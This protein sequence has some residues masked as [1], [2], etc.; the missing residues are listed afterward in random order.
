MITALNQRWRERRDLYRPAGEVIRTIQYEVAPL[1]DDTTPRTFVERHHYSGTYVA[2]RFRF[3]LFRGAELVGVAV[4]SH[5]CNDKALTNVFPGDALESV[6]LGRFVL[7]DDV[8]GNGETWFLGRCF[9]QLRT[10]GLNGVLSFSDP[11]PR[12]ALDG[13][14]VFRGHV[15]TIY[16]AHNARFLGRATARTLRLLPDGRSF[17]PYARQKVR[18]GKRGQAYAAGQLVA[19]G[20]APLEGDPAAWLAREIPRVTRTLRH[21][22]NYRYAWG[23]TR[24]ATRALPDG[25]PYPKFSRA[26]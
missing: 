11:V 7:T 23:L 24:A 1:A 21:P 10:E 15:G 17:H 14:V 3:G 13:R 12:T 8:P 18:S 22:G 26:A 19:A 4:F 9:E 5:P 6:E 2:A 16:Q 25:R 20:A